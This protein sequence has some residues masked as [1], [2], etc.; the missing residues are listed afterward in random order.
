MYTMCSIPID[1]NIGRNLIENALKQLLVSLAFVLG[2]N[3][4][5][6]ARNAAVTD[7]KKKTP[8]YYLEIGQVL[9]S[10]HHL[11]MP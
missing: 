7:L 4:N 2:L 6:N 11:P 9:T 1:R 5:T 10:S 3:W 8:K